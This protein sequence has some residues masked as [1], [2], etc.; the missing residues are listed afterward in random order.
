MG[1]M[2]QRYSLGESDFRGARFA[3]HP[4]ELKGNIDLLSLTQPEIICDIHNAFLAAGSD[5]VET[6]TFTATRV[7]Q[8]DYGRDHRANKIT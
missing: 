3:N 1:T 4:Q 5:I 6:N 8:A 7:S 2:V